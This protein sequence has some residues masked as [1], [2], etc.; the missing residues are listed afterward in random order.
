MSDLVRRAALEHGD[1]TVMAWPG[2]TVT[3]RTLD[4][5]VDRACSA[6]DSQAEVEIP[7]PRNARQVVR[8]LALLRA[9]GT[10][11]LRDPSGKSK[12]IL[13]PSSGRSGRIVVPTSGTSGPPRGVVHTEASLEASALG[14]AR[15]LDF[16]PGDRWPVTLSMHHVGGLAIL[17]RALVSGGTLV[18]PED[19]RDLCGIVQAA[20]H[21]S[22]VPTQFRRL[23]QSWAGEPPA[24]LRRVLLGGA[25][26]PRRLVQGAM[27]T[28]WPVILSYGLSEMGSLVTATRLGSTDSSGQVLAGRKIRISP[29]GEIEVGGDA[30]FESYL[31]DRPTGPWHATGDLGWLDDRGGL[32]VTGRRDNMFVSG[33]EN[34]H[35]EAIEAML[36]EIPGVEEVMVVSVPDEEFG[37][38]PVAFVRSSLSEDFLLGKAR[39]D[40]P[41][42][43]VPRAILDFPPGAASGIKRSRSELARLAA[44]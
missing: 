7:A 10:V 33:G 8:F 23:V 9:G 3:F 16:G 4:E 1:A 27:E 28:G 14:A 30:L 34:V 38:R 13:R 41:G 31:G 20:T 24:A 15:H 25:S 22:F 42:F 44:F 5:Q 39:A 12:P 19:L 26:A 29:S 21:V 43:M 36:S 37:S 35:P 2:G 6:L 40:L 17:Y 32:H 11:I 18:W